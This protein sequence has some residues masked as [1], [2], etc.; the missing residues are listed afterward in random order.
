MSGRNGEPH[1]VSVK[2]WSGTPKVVDENEC[3]DVQFLRAD[4]LGSQSF[5]LR[6]TLSTNSIAVSCT[7]DTRQNN[8]GFRF[9]TPYGCGMSEMAQ[10]AGAVARKYA[11]LRPHLDERQRRLALGLEASEL[12]RGGIKAVAAATGV[13][14]DTIARGVR[15]VAGEIEPTPWVRAPGG[16]R[17]KLADIDLSRHRRAPSPRPGRVRSRESPWQRAATAP[18]TGSLTGHHDPRAGGLSAQ[19]SLA[20]SARAVGGDQCPLHTP[21]ARFDSGPG[22]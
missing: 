9:G 13:H 1:A 12:G 11:V 6:A 7:K 19:V 4:D 15:E 5:S 16:G 14:P 10:V 18:R 21:G 3:V 22:D 17:K 2:Q 20:A 8:P